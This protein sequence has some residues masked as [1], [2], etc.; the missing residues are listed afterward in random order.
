MAVPDEGR[1]S[2]PQVILGRDSFGADG[3]GTLRVHRKKTLRV[4]GQRAHVTSGWKGISVHN[5]GC[6]E[7]RVSSR[8]PP[9][10]LSLHTTGHILP[11]GDT[12]IPSPGTAHKSLPEAHIHL[13]KICHKKKKR[14]LMIKIH[15]FFHQKDQEKHFRK[16]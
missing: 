7:V 10:D 14:K 12:G 6:G 2:G 11:D 15:G 1:K 16:E 3:T 9:P 8:R 4:M 5:T 13:T